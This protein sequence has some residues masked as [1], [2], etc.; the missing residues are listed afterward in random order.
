MVAGHCGVLVKGK[1]TAQKPEK[2][3]V[4]TNG[5]TSIYLHFKKKCCKTIFGIL[6]LEQE[7]AQ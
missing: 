7:L 6:I 4:P 3:K 5:K 2:V 1:W